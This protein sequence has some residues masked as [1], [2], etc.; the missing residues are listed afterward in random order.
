MKWFSVAALL[1]WLGAGATVA[2]GATLAACTSFDSTG[3]DGSTGANEGGAGDAVA[4]SADAGGDVP[5]A[6]ASAADGGSNDAAANDGASMAAST[7]DFGAPCALAPAC[8]RVVFA[9]NATVPA[10]FGGVAAADKVCADAASASMLASVR[11]RTFKA[12]MSD[13]STTPATRLVQGTGEYLR[14]DG[15]PIAASWAILIKGTLQNPL[16]ADENGHLISGA[17]WTGTSAS[18]SALGNATSRCGD[19][20]S[21]SSTQYGGVGSSTATA[22]GMWTFTGALAQCSISGH[23]YCFEQ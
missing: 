23:I 17:A 8:N 11:A 15:L 16:Q 14:T 1:L 5:A 18:G 20:M 4:P 3:D 6:D 12:W 9:T 13:P 19:W 10:S 21:V 22:S 2:I 7:V